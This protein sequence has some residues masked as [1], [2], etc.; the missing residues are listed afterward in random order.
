MIRRELRLQA[1]HARD[2]FRRAQRLQPPQQPR[3][4]RKSRR[5]VEPR[6]RSEEAGVRHAEVDGQRTAHR[7]RANRRRLLGRSRPAPASPATSR[8]RR[9]TST[10]P[11]TARRSGSK[12]A[13]ASAMRRSRS[14]FRISAT[15]RSRNKYS[16]GATIFTQAQTNY[17]P[18]YLNTPAPAPGI[19]ATPIPAGAP[20]SGLDRAR[21]PDQLHRSID[22]VAATYQ[23]SSTGFSTTLGRRLSDFVRAFRSA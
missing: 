21:R 14:R 18:V 22:G 2:R 15:P 17:Y 1:R 7:Y 16:L 4:L 23:T 8:T 20:R 6:A 10:A 3:L 13:R 19:T 11:A 9:T 5:H 12:R